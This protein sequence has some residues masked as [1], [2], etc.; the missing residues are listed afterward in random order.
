MGEFDHGR[1][2][3]NYLGEEISEDQIFARTKEEYFDPDGIP[4]W[5][6]YIQAGDGDG[7]DL[8]NVEENGR[9]IIKVILPAGKKVIRYGE[10]RGTFT[11]D[12]GI[13]YEMIS[14]PYMKESVPYHEYV[15]LKNTEVECYVDRG[16]AAPGFGCQGG[17]VQ[18]KHYF[19]IH[20]S[21]M[22]GLLEEDFSWLRDR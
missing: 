2:K 20:E 19:T 4:R 10:P 22:Q 17:G 12:E 9:Y 18:Y 15:I 21:I 8:H 11:T 14:L 3:Y 5:E 7:F 1:I 6:E 16:K 13:P